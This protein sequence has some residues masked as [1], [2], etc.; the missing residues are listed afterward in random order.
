MVV[1]GG[2][3]AVLRRKPE[4]LVAEVELALLKGHEAR[5]GEEPGGGLVEDLK[6][7]LEFGGVIQSCRP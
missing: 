2:E 6:D 5:G 4:G 7:E 1:E 3:L